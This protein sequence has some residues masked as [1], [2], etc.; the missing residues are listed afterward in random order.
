MDP[1]I[2]QHHQKYTSVTN[3]NYVQFYVL[4][5][6]FQQSGFSLGQEEQAKEP[7]KYGYSPTLFPL[8]KMWSGRD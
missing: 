3:R 7:M 5:R 4:Q 2:V 8:H 6:L 1:H